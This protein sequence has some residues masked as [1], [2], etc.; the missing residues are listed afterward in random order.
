MWRDLIA[1]TELEYDDNNQEWDPY[2]TCSD[3]KYANSLLNSS[4]YNLVMTIITDKN[5]HA[6]IINTSINLLDLAGRNFT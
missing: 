1:T 5:T 2:E 3:F 4:E 6:K